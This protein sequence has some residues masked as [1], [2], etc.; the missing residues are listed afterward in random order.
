MKIV[1]L[2]AASVGESVDFSKFSALGEFVAYDYSNLEQVPARVVDADIIITNKLLINAQTVGAAPNL[3]LVCVTATGTNNLD[4]DYLATR[5]IAWRNAAGYS[6][7]SVVQ[8]TF[9]LLLY[10]LEKM[11][12]Y[13]K[14]VKDE[15]YV[16]DISFTHFAMDFNEISG[17]TW[18]IIGLGEIGRGVAKVAQAFGAHVIYHSPSGAAPQAGYNQV[19]L[20]TLLAT[21]DFVTVHAPLNEHTEGLMNAAA[22]AKM[23]PSALFVNV[24]RGPIVVEQDL[25]DALNQ[26]VIAGAGIDVLCHEPMLPENPLRTIKDSNK[27]VVTPHIAWASVEA[28]DN[29]MRIVYDHIVAFLG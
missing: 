10:L 18:G 29:L 26:G 22:F 9:S 20:D 6:T 11:H 14:Y 23:K 28:R 16:N 7:H 2:D 5:N 1:F 3:K 12:Y 25:V 24:G 19:D 13:D 15:K 17:K 4:K 8:H 27:L 21:S